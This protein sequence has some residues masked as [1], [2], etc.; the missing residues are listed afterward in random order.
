[1]NIGGRLAY[2]AQPTPTS[3]ENH[4]DLMVPLGTAFLAL[5]ATSALAL[6][7]RPGSLMSI[8]TL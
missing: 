1:M 2:F 6:S 7:R 8:S 3:H 4:T 5:A